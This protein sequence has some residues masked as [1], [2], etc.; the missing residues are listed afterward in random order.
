MRVDEVGC[1][2]EIWSLDVVGCETD[3]NTVSLH[4]GDVTELV[5]L[6]AYTLCGS[7]TD[8]VV[9]VTLVPIHFKID[10]VVE[11]AGRQSEVKLVLLLVCEFIVCEVLDVEH[12]LT[13]TCERTPRGLAT[14]FYDSV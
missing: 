9:V 12:T 3:F 14:D 1:P 6:T 11:E 5:N 2:T 10:A 4:C 7:N 8:K 13:N